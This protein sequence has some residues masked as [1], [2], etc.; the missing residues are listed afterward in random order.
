MTRCAHRCRARRVGAAAPRPRTDRPAARPSSCQAPDCRGSG[1]ATPSPRGAGPGPQSPMPARGQPDGDADGGTCDE[2][3]GRPRSECWRPHHDDARSYPVTTTEST[4]DAQGT[5]QYATVN[6]IELYFERHGSG[7][8]LVLLHGGLGSGE[9]FG[10]V[11]PALSE[12]H[13]VITVDLQGHG[14]TADI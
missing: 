14:R 1:Q 2:F 3:S 4:K 10:P 7:R 6:G 9:M 13:Q 5:G 11:L 12:K 8:P